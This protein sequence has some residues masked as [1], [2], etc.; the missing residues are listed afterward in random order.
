M[1][2]QQVVHEIVLTIEQLTDLM[3]GCGTVGI[4]T[5]TGEK[6]VLTGVGSHS[7]SGRGHTFKTNMDYKGLYLWVNITLFPPENGIYN[8]KITYEI[9]PDN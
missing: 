2:F 6:M 8:G 1:G 4:N 5:R 3:I 7:R 9:Y